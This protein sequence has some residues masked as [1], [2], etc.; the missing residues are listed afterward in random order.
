MEREREG[1]EASWQIFFSSS[2]VPCSLELEEIFE[3][4]LF[5]GKSILLQGI[6]LAIIHFKYS[7]SNNM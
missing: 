4:E 5:N 7:V 6:F 3:Y 2:H 1:Y